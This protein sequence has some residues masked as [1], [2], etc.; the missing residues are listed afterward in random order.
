MWFLGKKVCNVLR[1]RYI[2][3]GYLLRLKPNLSSMPLRYEWNPQGFFSSNFPWL[4]FCLFGV[5]NIVV[6][7]IEE[8]SSNLL[9]FA[10]L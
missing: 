2:F 1:L 9:I 5:V 6:Y 4:S 3:A 7:Q 8:N 10:S